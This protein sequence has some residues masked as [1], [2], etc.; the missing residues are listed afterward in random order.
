MSKNVDKLINCIIAIVVG[1]L[2]LAAIYF[3][4]KWNCVVGSIVLGFGY[5]I[6]C[7][8]TQIYPHH[9]DPAGD[10]M[11][12]GFAALFNIAKSVIFA[13]TFML[14]MLLSDNPATVLNVSMIIL[15][16][17]CVKRLLFMIF[18]IS[19]I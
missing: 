11:A 7:L 15:I 13:I 6:Y 18:G 9:S 10:G 17:F 2:V 4:S 1:A 8:V 16:V 3:S 14:F 19:F 12:E 5:Y